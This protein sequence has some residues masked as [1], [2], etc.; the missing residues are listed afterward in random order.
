M[1]SQTGIPDNTRVI[2][3]F[4]TGGRFLLVPGKKFLPALPPALPVLDT[5]GAALTGIPR[6]I[7]QM[8]AFHL[9]PLYPG[10]LE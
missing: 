2:F 10:G 4:L 8:I 6:L 9:K 5:L 7:Y 1:P 3:L